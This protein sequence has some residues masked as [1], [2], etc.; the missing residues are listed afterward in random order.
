[1]SNGYMGKILFVDLS[2]GVIKEEALEEKMCRDFIGGYGIGAR[3]IYSRQKAGVDP[4][5]PENT[6]GFTTGPFTGTLV[7]TAARYTA[8]GKSPL[9][10]GWGEAHS[11][12]SFGPYLK[13]SG[14]DAVFFTGISPK[15][16]YLLIDNGKA[17]LKDAGYLWGK[18]T[19]ETE[20][21]LEAEYGKQSRVA[22]IGPAGEQLTLI[23]GIMT[24]HGSTAGR[25][26]LGAVMGS[27]KLKSVVVRGTMEVPVADK[28]TLQKLRMEQIQ[29]WKVPRWS[30]LAHIDEMHTFGTTAG[31]YNSAHSG[32]SPVKNWG[33]I[34]V[35]D[36]PDRAN[37]HRDAI[38][39]RVEK[40][41][42][43]WH[44]PIACKATMKAGEGEYKYAAGVRRPEYETLA[45]FGSNCL[46][47]NVE[48]ITTVN[49]ICNRAGIDTISAGTII[50]F[51]I[52]LYENGI[53]TKK[54]TDG[55]EMKWGNHQAIV[56]MTAKLANREGLGDILADGVKIAAEK[57]GKG[58]DKFAIHIGGQEV[59]MHDPKIAWGDRAATYQM[60]ATPGR[61]MSN[62]GPGGFPVHIVNITGLCSFSLYGFG[63][64]PESE[65]LLTG[66]FNAV[67]GWNYTWGDLLKSA[68]RVANI[69]HA[70]NLREGINQ[71][72][73][74]VN[75]RIVGKPPQPAGPLAGVTADIEAQ[76][77]WRLGA[78]DWDRVT[79]KPSKAKLLSLGLDDV[80]KDLWP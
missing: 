32:D 3:I 17:Q 2:T 72:K 8:V 74:P 39:P 50:G 62:F 18:D 47:N 43:C 44:C 10:G 77:Y 68:E 24:D 9:T 38:A 63:T 79:T 36:F 66:I 14:F 58:A 7:P 80:T 4:L 25:S 11:G 64:S 19:Y 22:C 60:D 55:L 1:M 52:E 59:G 73:Y 30:G 67:T 6:L 42:G 26:G 31:A 12:G 69:R 71:L 21:T 45:A 16:V 13:F 27:K 33:G 51:V 78:L 61:H 23:A 54:D 34:G 28:E 56:A 48:A 70:F 37:F 76:V 65:K 35:I 41:S 20:D 46:N 53:L 5:G 49:D 75:P 15:P 40:L 29:V 57:I